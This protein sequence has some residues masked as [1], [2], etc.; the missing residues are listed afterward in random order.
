MR[1]IKVKKPFTYYL[2]GYDKRDFSIGEYEVPLD[3]AAYAERRGFVALEESGEKNA[4][5]SQPGRSKKTSA[6]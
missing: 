5:T 3:C 6:S 1:K 4:G 2:N